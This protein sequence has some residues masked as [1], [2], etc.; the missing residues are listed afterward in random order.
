MAGDAHVFADQQDTERSNGPS[1][2]G[3]GDPIVQN[4][5]NS[6]RRGWLTGDVVAQGDLMMRNKASYHAVPVGSVRMGIG[7]DAVSCVWAQ[8]RHGQGLACETKPM[9]R[10]EGDGSI[11]QQ[12]TYGRS[13]RLCLSEETK[14]IC[15]PRDCFVASLLAVTYEAM[16][17]ARRWGKCA[18]QSQLAEGGHANQSQS[19][20]GGRWSAQPTLRSNAEVAVRNKANLRRG[21]TEARG[22]VQNKANSAGRGRLPRGPGWRGCVCENK[23]APGYRWRYSLSVKGLRDKENANGWSNYQRATEEGIGQGLREAAGGGG[24]GGQ[25]SAAGSY[26]R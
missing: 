5:A 26:H 22:T 9:Y 4:K 13:D 18:K 8:R 10:S 6:G 11:I 3:V 23:L 17:P 1:P 12:R 19:I 24:R 21:S 16:L 14:P 25:P 15:Q 20:A 7:R 2:P